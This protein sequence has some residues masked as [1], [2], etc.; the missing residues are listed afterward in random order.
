ML[1]YLTIIVLVILAAVSCGK[2]PINELLPKP[3]ECDVTITQMPDRDKEPVKLK[4]RFENCKEQSA[5]SG[6]E[7]H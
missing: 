4:A 3:I 5:E 7:L 1:F 6:I 2:P